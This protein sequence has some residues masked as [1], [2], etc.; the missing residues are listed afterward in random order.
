MPRPRLLDSWQRRLSDAL[1][2]RR[3]L[4]AQRQ[5]EAW[6]LRYDHA[7]VTQLERL[8]EQWLQP[9]EVL[10]P[11]FA[12]LSRRK[13]HVKLH[14]EVRRDRHA[15]MIRKSCHLEKWRDASHSRGVRLEDVRAP[16]LEQAPVLGHAGQHL[17]G[18]DRCVEL[19]GELSVSG[20][21]ERIERLLDPDQVERF[22][23]STHA[24]C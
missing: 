12:W 23:P 20:R 17:T 1:L 4:L 8:V 10:D 2:P 24:Q 21:V 11:G 9:V 13:V 14:R 22:E 18:R 19:A 16:G 5:A 6:P 7:T 15:H 3:R